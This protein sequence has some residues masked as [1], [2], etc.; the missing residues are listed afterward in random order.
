MALI[1]S[2]NSN[3]V[4]VD[5]TDELFNKYC[6]G[7][8]LVQLNDGD[9]IKQVIA[10]DGVTPNIR[11]T[12]FRLYN[13]AQDCGADVILNLC[14]SVGQAAEDVAKLIDV[15][16]FRIDLPMARKAAE[17]S[18]DIGV[19]ATVRTT[20]LPTSDIIERCGRDIGKAMNVTQHLAEG[21]FEKLLDGDRDAHDEILIAKAEDVAKSVDVI[22]FAQATMAR[23]APAVTEKTGKTVLT[24]FES[25]MQ[26]LAE[27]VRHRSRP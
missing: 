4:L 21:A 14:S 2:I 25:G 18:S 17:L 20:L 9:M 8:K 10:K 19:M 11:R 23:L 16:V 26:G 27:F 15:P 13:I 22:V 1:Y 12:L 7:H 3:N 5:I 6:P 24:S